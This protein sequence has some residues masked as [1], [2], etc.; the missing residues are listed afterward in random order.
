MGVTLTLGKPNVIRTIDEPYGASHQIVEFSYDMKDYEAW[1][2]VQLAYTLTP[3]ED[4]ADAKELSSIVEA[5]VKNVKS[6]EFQ[7]H[8]SGSR[9]APTS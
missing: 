9:D 1:D 4:T 2:R 6:K 7:I 8:N 3:A 5:L